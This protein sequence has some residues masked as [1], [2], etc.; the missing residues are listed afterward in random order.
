[1]LLIEPETLATMLPELLSN[2][3]PELPT[4]VPLRLAAMFPEL[5][6]ISTA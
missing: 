4:S 1:M 5:V 6:P 2:R 3:A